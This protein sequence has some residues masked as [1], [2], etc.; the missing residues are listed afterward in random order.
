M[1]NFQDNAWLVAVFFAFIVFCVVAMIL[2]NRAA[3][4]D[5]VGRSEKDTVI[6]SVSIDA[7]EN[8]TKLN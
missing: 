8:T 5:S 1:P 3:K 7:K 2:R 6:N 4:T